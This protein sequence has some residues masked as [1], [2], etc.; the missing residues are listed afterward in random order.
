MSIQSAAN[1]QGTQGSV[2]SSTTIGL[3]VLACLRLFVWAHQRSLAR[4]VCSPSPS[5]ARARALLVPVALVPVAI[6]QTHWLWR[7]TVS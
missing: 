6:W 7:E 3:Q 1:S 4:C 2:L 5:D